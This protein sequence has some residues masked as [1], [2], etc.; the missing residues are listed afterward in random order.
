MS[1]R[2][3]YSGINLT[4]GA[5]CLH[6]KICKMQIKKLKTTQTDGKNILCFWIR[7]INIV[8]MATLPKAT[9]R[10]NAI[11]DKL[12]M[13]FFHRTETN[14]FQICTETPKTLNSQNI[15]RKKN[16]ARKIMFLDFGLHYMAT[17][18]KTVWY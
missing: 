11:P 1:E 12:P 13:A 4:K 16:E 9:Y 17:L 8:K 7:R 6:F 5:K 14:I 18:V 15:L 3:K 10:F 2:T